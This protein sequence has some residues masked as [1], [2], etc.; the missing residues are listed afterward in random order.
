MKKKSLLSELS[1]KIA[2]LTLAI[3]GAFMT[4]CYKDDGL[5]ANSPGGNSNP[6]TPVYVISGV[7]TDAE[8]GENIQGNVT[9]TD[10]T[11]QTLSF[12]GS[13][14]IKIAE[15]NEETKTVSLSFKANDETYNG[16]KAI[17]RTVVL[18][19]IENGNAVYPVDVIMKKNVSMYP[20]PYNLTFIYKNAVTGEEIASD[21]SDQM[22]MTIKS[23]DGTAVTNYNGLASG[24]YTIRTQAI[25]KAFK[26]SVTLLS[27]P[28]V[29]SETKDDYINKIVELLI[30]PADPDKEDTYTTLAGVVVDKDG[31]SLLADKIELLKDGTVVNEK[32]ITNSA[33]FVFTVNDK[34]K[35]EYKIQV[36][37]GNLTP[38]ISGIYSIPACGNQNI[39]II[40]QKPIAPTYPRNYMLTYV[41]KNALTGESINKETEGITS[42]PAEGKFTPGEYAITTTTTTDK[43]KSNVTHITLEEV[44]ESATEN[45]FIK[46]TIVISLTP[47]DSKETFTT[48]SGTIINDNGNAVMADKIELFKEGTTTAV[49][50]ITK[51]ASF[52]F[53]INNEDEGKYKI[54]AT[55]GTKDIITE[56]YTV[57]NCG[58]QIIT[59]VFESDKPAELKDVVYN[60]TFKAFDIDTKVE[61]SGVTFNFNGNPGS[62][63][64]SIAHGTYTLTATADKYYTGQVTIELPAMKNES[65]IAAQT[66]IVYLQK[67]PT[68]EDEPTKVIL[69]GEVVDALGNMVMA[70]SIKLNDPS[71]AV[72]N[73]NHF[74][75][76]IE[77]PAN[78][79]KAS[80]LKQWLITAK[81]SK[82]NSKGEPLAPIEMPVTFVYDP[83][84]GTT[85]INKNISIP[86]TANKDG[87]IVINETTEPGDGEQGQVTP[88]VD[89]ETGKVEA[90]KTTVMNG[91]GTPEDKTVIVIEKGTTIQTSE[92]TPLIS[93]IILTRDVKEEKAPTGNLDAE[94]TQPK[95]LRSFYGNP[96]GAMF[97]G[98]PLKVTFADPYEGELGSLQLEYKDK[99][100]GLWG[101]S[102]NND[103]DEVVTDKKEYTML[104]SHFSQFRAA[105]VGTL[106][107]GTSGENEYGNSYTKEVNQQNNTDQTQNLKITFKDAPTGAIYQSLEESIAK[108]FKNE[109]AQS[110]VKSTIENIFTSRGEPINSEFKKEDKELTLTVDPFTYVESIQ[111]KTVYTITTYKFI[112]NGKT[113]EVIVKSVSGHEV[114]AKT[115]PIGHGHGHGHGD[116]LNAGGG[117]IVSE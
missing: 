61:I 13:Y 36:T 101:V 109:N 115:L 37:V 33:N 59:I 108:V 53:T 72:Y 42:N 23:A 90:E 112:L 18:N 28:Y 89:P 75:F 7:V 65:G 1:A 111:V 27:L 83:A 94:G 103:N 95:V 32:T 70:Q 81:V 9:Y 98:N 15:F 44:A 39:T 31:N 66:I 117:I 69:M 96:D 20:R 19:K 105:V 21:I 80:N 74:S 91:N 57:P 30:T 52:T 25:E 51:S 46:K 82:I 97:V 22:G 88:D 55:K 58:N 2:L 85:A 77:I 14:S 40:A 10:G 84:K 113:V 26:S 17:V 100:T 41:Y 102:G 99:V 6:L 86:F 114:T 11:S 79:A 34:E 56:G 71:T 29:E 63:A 54:K 12:D 106:D 73:T 38:V 3:S 50:T 47:V 60:L 4:G 43:F 35:G 107:D 93:P 45:D 78:K 76:E 48:L 110:I 104:V 92:G 62:T 24:N 87:I 5:D 116:D 16:G 67:E 64:S 49:K 68:K 8:T